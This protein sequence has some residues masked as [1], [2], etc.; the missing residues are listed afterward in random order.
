MLEHLESLRLAL[1]AQKKDVPVV[2]VS[3]VVTPPVVAPPIRKWKPLGRDHTDTSSGVRPV[4]PPLEPRRIISAMIDLGIPAEG[5]CGTPIVGPTVTTYII[6]L[7]KG[8]RVSTIKNK[9]VD[10]AFSL[11]L[12]KVRVLDYVEGHPGSI[13]LE[14]PNITRGLVSFWSV[15]AAATEWGKH[16]PIPLGLDTRGVPVII[17]L[18][19]APHLLIAGKS[20]SGKSVAVNSVLAGIAACT[21]P[22]EVAVVIADPKQVDYQAWADLPHLVTAPA[23]TAEAIAAVLSYAVDEMDSRNKLLRESGVNCLAA[24]NASVSP[25]MRIPRLVVVIDEYGDLMVKGSAIRGG[26][27]AAAMTMDILRIAQVGRAAGVHL[28]L[29]TQ[30]PTADTVHPTIKAQ[31]TKIAC[32]VETALDSRVILDDVGAEKLLGAGDALI[33]SS[34]VLTRVQCAWVSPED[35]RNLVAGG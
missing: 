18:D 4:P 16:L 26:S 9:S 29:A 17:H 11:G 15:L 27:P 7:Q 1:L 19:T 31:T 6:E 30:R 23:I 28:V 33:K 12:P 34:S 35:I 8:A 22:E 20:G 10:L 21:T 13:G 32:T 25:E 3:P 14:V 2:S 24:Y 5:I